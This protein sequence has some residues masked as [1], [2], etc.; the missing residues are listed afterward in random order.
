[1]D[2]GFILYFYIVS[3]FMWCQIDVFQCL[4]CLREISRAYGEP[5]GNLAGGTLVR[6]AS[7][8]STMHREYR[9]STRMRCLDP[10]QKTINLKLIKHILNIWN[11]ELSE[12][13]DNFV[14]RCLEWFL[15]STSTDVQVIW[16]SC[17]ELSS[18]EAGGHCHNMSQHV[19]H[20]MSQH[21]TTC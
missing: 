4:R 18:L 11:I 9:E 19:T 7:T 8:T 3:C 21:V 12:N 5:L 6:S 1:M 2:E 14:W 20:N 15:Q 13:M 17:P 10:Q 16:G